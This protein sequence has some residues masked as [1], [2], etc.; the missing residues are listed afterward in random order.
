MDTPAN[1]NDTSIINDMEE[2]SLCVA[3]HAYLSDRNQPLIS[4]EKWKSMQ[5][6]T[7]PATY[8]DRL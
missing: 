5:I 4:Y 3:Y 6:N 7:N 1:D 2:L 8:G